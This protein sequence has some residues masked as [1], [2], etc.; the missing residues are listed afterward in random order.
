MATREGAAK[1]ASKVGTGT[2]GESMGD[3]G[4]T[5]VVV[6]G[7]RHGSRTDEEDLHLVLARALAGRVDQA[8][9][10]DDERD[11]GRAIDLPADGGDSGH[12]LPRRDQRAGGQAPDQGLGLDLDA[13]VALHHHATGI[14]ADLEEAAEA[15]R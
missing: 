6:G 11:L 2:T 12:A 8:A 5:G 3:G 1:K 15:H 4:L 9:G 7:Q 14:G 10:F 13:G